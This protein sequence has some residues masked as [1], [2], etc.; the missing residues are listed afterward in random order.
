MVATEPDRDEFH[1]ANARIARGESG[2]VFLA[3]DIDGR[4][5]HITSDQKPTLLSHGLVFLGPEWED[6]LPERPFRNNLLRGFTND[7][8]ISALFA[9]FDRRIN[10]DEDDG[11]KPT[12][13]IPIPP[14]SP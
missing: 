11:P 14:E 7:P 10:W 5:A 1:L 9:E 2:Y 3:L 12:G 6:R 4:A 13:P 8:R